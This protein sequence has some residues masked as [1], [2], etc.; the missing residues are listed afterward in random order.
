MPKPQ[1]VV[2]GGKIRH[3][4]DVGKGI[5]D[6]SLA[7]AKTVVPENPES[8]VNENFIKFSDQGQ[9]KLLS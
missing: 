4:N 3:N 7:I 5:V 2:G 9:T 1:G 6:R 8:V